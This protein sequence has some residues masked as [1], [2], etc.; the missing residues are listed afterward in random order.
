MMQPGRCESMREL[1]AEFHDGELGID[2]QIA[3]QA[4]LR[5]CV[6]CAIESAEILELGRLMREAATSL[7]V[8]AHAESHMP[9]LMLERVRVEERLSW[10][11]RLRDVFD[12]MHLVWPALGATAATVVCL[13]GAMGVLQA[14]SREHPESLAGMI[15]HLASTTRSPVSGFDDGSARAADVAM[16]EEAVFALA[17]AVTREGRIQSVQALAAEQGRALGVT[18][19]VVLAM[20]EAASRAQF[21][22]AEPRGAPIAVSMVWVLSPTSGT[23]KL[24]YELLRVPT[25]RGGAGRSVAPGTKRPTLQDRPARPSAGAKSSAR[26]SATA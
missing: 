18:P 17:A 24:D 3:V 12:D 9:A 2:D 20:L 10:R 5:E 4:H 8:A 13:L 7:P 14:A 19:E 22:P 1:L 15:S 21:S 11:A 6:A 26:P 16:G 25:G 23:G